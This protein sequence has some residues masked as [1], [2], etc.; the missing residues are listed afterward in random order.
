[1]ET[2]QQVF[3]VLSHPLAHKF[4]CIVV[5]Y[6]TFAA[7]ADALPNPDQVHNGFLK[8]AV[9]AAHLLAMN[10]KRAAKIFRKMAHIPEAEG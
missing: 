7:C 4:F 10:V 6:L 8:W 1:M 9:A 5:V 3:A 2:L